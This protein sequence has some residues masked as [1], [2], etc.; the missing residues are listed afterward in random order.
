MIEQLGFRA[1]VAGNGKEVLEALSRISYDVILMDCQMPE[2]D[3][4]DATRTIRKEENKKFSIQ[5]E[6]GKG[7]INHSEEETSTAHFSLSKSHSRVA[8]IAMTANAMPGDRE[9]CLE[10][11][12]DDYL[13]KP[14][15]S[16]ELAKVLTMWLPQTGSIHPTPSIQGEKSHTRGKR[17]TSRLRL[18]Q[19]CHIIRLENSRRRKIFP[20]DD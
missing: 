19:R 12:M 15:R 6:E 7:N 14:L 3:G 9:K 1:D 10:A 18:R 20:I 11:G 17:R 13:S 8:I 2:M 16:D 5:G 4:Y